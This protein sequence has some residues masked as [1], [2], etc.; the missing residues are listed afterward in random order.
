MPVSTSSKI[1]NNARSHLPSRIA[2]HAAAHAAALLLFVQHVPHGE[3]R[4]STRRGAVLRCERWTR[5]LQSSMPLL[6]SLCSM[7]FCNWRTGPLTLPA[8]LWRALQT[9]ISLIPA[10]A[11]RSR[12]RTF[13]LTSWRLVVVHQTMVCC[14]SVHDASTLSDRAGGWAVAIVLVGSLV[15]R[16]LSASAVGTTGGKPARSRSPSPVIVDG[17]G[18]AHAVPASSS[19]PSIEWWCGGGFEWSMERAL[20]EFAHFLRSPGALTRLRARS[21]A[22]EPSLR[23]AVGRFLPA[24]PM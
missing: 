24:R 20:H 2:A 6:Y 9:P 13:L 18:A 19:Y 11:S 23:Q 15:D 10:M 21:V 16:V 17:G 8:A 12:Q 5:R 4:A 7:A 3:W 1:G 14:T 22:A